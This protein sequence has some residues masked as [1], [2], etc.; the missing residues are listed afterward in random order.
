M[1]R[2]HLLVRGWLV[3]AVLVVGGIA[4]AQNDRLIIGATAEVSGLDP[5]LATDVS[6]FQRINVMLEPLVVFDRNLHLQPRLA[7]AWELADD[8]LSLTFT[9]REG[10]TFHDGRPFT[11]EDV[12]YTFETM[13]DPDFG[14]PNRSLYVAIDTIDT[15]D[16]HTV[17]FNLSVPNVF[18]INNLA[19]MPILPA[20][21]GEDF[22]QN[23]VGTGPYKFVSLVRDDRAIMERFDDYWGGA[24]QLAFIEFR[25]I[26]ENATRLLA[27]ESGDLDV[28]QGQLPTTELSRLESDARFV[29]ERTPGTGYSYVGFNLLEQPLDNV[30]VR[31]AFNHLIPREAIVERV[32]NGNGFAG[33]S[34]LL[35]VMPWFNPDTRVFDYNP[36][37]ARQLIAESGVTFD[38][39]LRLF[40][41]EDAVR[42]QTAEIL[43]FEFAQLGVEIEIHIEEWAAFLSRIQSTE[44]YDIFILGWSGQLDPDR[45]M[46]RQFHSGQFG[47]A[48]Y[49][50]YSNP[51]VDE[52]LELG[53]RT[54]PT[55]AESVAIYQE[56]SAIVVE[57]SSYAFMYYAEETA[58]YHPSIGG[59]GVHSYSPNTFQDAHLITKGN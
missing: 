57:E 43:A 34:M 7:T 11:S 56:A 22:G 15:P 33:I 39:P 8:L 54:D 6:S 5:R 28:T 21:A 47:S 30:A 4:F 31:Q 3:A 49:V 9:L 44:D 24:G 36:E 46:I 32:L 29:L 48:N 23:P 25:T 2:Q 19:R 10:V 14:A 38:R 20:N 37:A 12:R 59:W 13:L 41:N 51:R 1:S 42:M 27:F 55:S 53:A 52:L 17:V 58:L 45:A 40:T 35:P 18:L 26:T 50:Y 16:D